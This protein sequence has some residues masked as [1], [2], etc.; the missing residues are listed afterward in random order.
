VLGTY[1]HGL[2][3]SDAFRAHFLSGFRSGETRLL[4]YEARI[5]ATLD[6]LADHVARHIDCDRLMTIAESRVHRS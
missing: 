3:A 4:A 1:I 5:D 2:F 6:A